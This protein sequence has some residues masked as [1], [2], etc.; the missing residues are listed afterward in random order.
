VTFYDYDR[1]TEF[2]RNQPANGREFGE[3]RGPIRQLLNLRASKEFRLGAGRKLVVDVDA[4]NA[5]NSNTESATT[6]YVSGRT[7]GYATRIVP[8]R[9]L[10]LG[11][12]MEV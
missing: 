9:A 4:F 3:V 6:S 11:V 10:R 1:R 12:R 7:F 5:L 2:D 8:P